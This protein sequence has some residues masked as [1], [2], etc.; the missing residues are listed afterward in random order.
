MIENGSKSLVLIKNQI[1]PRTKPWGTPN[2]FS[3]E[4]DID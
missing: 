2:I 1:G 3:I 4:S